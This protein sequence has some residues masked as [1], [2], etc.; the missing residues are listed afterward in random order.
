[1]FWYSDIVKLYKITLRR[2]NHRLNCFQ[3][4]SEGFKSSKYWEA[5]FKAHYPVAYL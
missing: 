1:M 3:S 5:L 2:R 4:E